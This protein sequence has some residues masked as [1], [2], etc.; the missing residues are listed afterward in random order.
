LQK[1]TV[2]VFISLSGPV[3]PEM[4]KSPNIVP[5]IAQYWALLWKRFCLCRKC[6]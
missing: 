6:N 3:W 2:N 5:K 4:K 1:S